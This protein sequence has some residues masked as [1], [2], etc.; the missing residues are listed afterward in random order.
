M[1]QQ[2]KKKAFRECQPSS[3]LNCYPTFSQFWADQ[4]PKPLSLFLPAS[5]KSHNERI[6]HLPVQVK[7][8]S[9]ILT[10]IKSSNS[11]FD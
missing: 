11:V 3:T 5:E 7:L 10:G 9:K 4:F 6:M 8:I 2:K 1:L